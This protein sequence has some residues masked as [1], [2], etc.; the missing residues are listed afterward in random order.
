MSC[1]SLYF[2]L[3]SLFFLQVSLD[4]ISSTLTTSV[5]CI[6]KYSNLGHLAVNISSGVKSDV[7]AHCNALTIRPEPCQGS[8]SVE[9]W[10]LMY[11]GPLFNHSVQAACCV[12]KPSL[13]VKGR[14]FKN[15]RNMHWVPS[16]TT[17]P[18]SHGRIKC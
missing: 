2:T 9:D 7:P 6:G 17:H 16:M 3:V 13:F 15:M 11:R 12:M 5:P 10:S 4:A 8:V 14:V 1:V 18:T